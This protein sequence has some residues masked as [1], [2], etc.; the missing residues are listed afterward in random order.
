MPNKT[1]ICHFRNEEKMLPYWLLHHYPLFDHGI[2]IDYYSTDNSVELIRLLAP[3]WEIRTTKNDKFSTH[4][5]DS[6]VM[7]IER[8]IDEWKMCLNVSEFVIHHDL[9]EYICSVSVSSSHREGGVITT[10]FVMQDEPELIEKDLPEL[11]IPLWEQRHFG[12]AEPDPV[13][14]YRTT[15]SRLLHCKRDGG[16]GPGRHTNNVSGRKDPFLA[17]LWYGWSPLWLK[18][19]K[20]KS[21]QSMLDEKDLAKGWGAHHN[22]NK[23]KIYETW[24]QDYLKHCYNIFDGRHLELNK[25][26]KEVK[27]KHPSYMSL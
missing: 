12:Y 25:A 21:T 18:V 3:G 5:I 23:E 27:E 20:N 13:D 2:M 22:L 6:E 1:V 9:N 14:K 4:E 10:G 19:Q 26:I 15:R 17:L 16:Y 24:Q 7:D 8:S 11:G